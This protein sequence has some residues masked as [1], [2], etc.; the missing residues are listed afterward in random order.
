[1]RRQPRPKS[2]L[3]RRR[4]VFGLY[5]AKVPGGRLS[6]YSVLIPRSSRRLRTRRVPS[7][8]CESRMTPK[9]GSRPDRQCGM[10]A[11]RCLVS[12]TNR[13]G[14]RRPWCDECARHVVRLWP[15]GSIRIVDMTAADREMQVAEH[16]LGD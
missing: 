8:W 14:A 9:S 13:V 6:V 1:M 4:V 5:L 12:R 7:G 2:S 3:E 10:P 16:A 15:G 11:T